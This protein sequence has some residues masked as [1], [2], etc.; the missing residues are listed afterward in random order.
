VSKQSPVRAFEIRIRDNSSST[1]VSCVL[2]H[3]CL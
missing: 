3:P 1:D 2:S